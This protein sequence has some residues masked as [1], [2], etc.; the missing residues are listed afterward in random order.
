MPETK[1][2]I[3]APVKHDAKKQEPKVTIEDR[4]LKVEELRSMTTKRQKTLST[5][6][7]LKTFQFASDDSCFIAITDSQGQKFQTGNSN[8]VN[9]LRSY[10]EA[11]LHDKIAALDDEILAFTI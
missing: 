2:S 1:A 3:P 5:L 9:L 8:L 11:V 4:I 6:H 7:Q 10:L